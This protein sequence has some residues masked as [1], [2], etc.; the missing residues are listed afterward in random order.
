MPKSSATTPGKAST[1][2][3][4][5]LVTDYAPQLQLRTLRL[6]PTGIQKHIYLGTRESDGGTDYL[7]SFIAFA[8]QAG[9]Y[10]A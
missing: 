4:K 8:R 9:R 5:W 7:Q 3:P 1:A 10:P 6:G 2:L